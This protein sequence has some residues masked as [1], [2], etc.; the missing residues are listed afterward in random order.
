MILVRLD[1]DVASELLYASQVL[2]VTYCALD[3]EFPVARLKPFELEYEYDSDSLLI[4][5]Y[6]P[7][8][9]MPVRLYAPLE[10]GFR[11][12]SSPCNSL[13]HLKSRTRECV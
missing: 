2:L 1:E 6:Y 5:H 4:L 13:F 11:I 3:T 8:H 12:L 9:F 7:D 10:Y